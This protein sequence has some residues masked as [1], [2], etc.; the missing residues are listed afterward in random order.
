VNEA[1]RTIWLRGYDYGLGYAAGHDLT[2]NRTADLV[3]KMM[4]DLEQYLWSDSAELYLRGYVDGMND[5]VLS[6]T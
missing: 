3:M 6:A 4:V 1:E 2:N 5:A